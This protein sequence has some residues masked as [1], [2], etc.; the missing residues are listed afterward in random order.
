MKDAHLPQ[1]KHTIFDPKELN[2]PQT[3]VTI[4][5]NFLL[6]DLQASGK[7]SPC[8]HQHLQIG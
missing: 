5:N 2:K 7:Q 1:R 8:V 3:C 4:H 6:V